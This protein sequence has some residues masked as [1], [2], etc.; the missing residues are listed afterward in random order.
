MSRRGFGLW[1][2]RRRRRIVASSVSTISTLLRFLCLCYT[3]HTMTSNHH[4]GLTAAIVVILVVVAAVLIFRPEAN[5]ESGVEL[6]TFIDKGLTPEAQAEFD[7]RIATLKA[8]IEASEEFNGHDHL[9][10]GNLYYQVG[11]LELAKDAYEAILA[12]SPEDVGALENLGVALELMRDYEGAARAW[13]KALSLSGSVTTVIRLV[14]IIE[15]SLPEQYDRVDDVL[16]LAIKSLGQDEQ[17]NGRLAK[18]YFGNGEYAEAQS[19]YEVAETLSG[20]TG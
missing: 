12:Q 8:S 17:L 14:D 9:L 6:R 4:H 5:H 3:F 19:H 15:N 2:K 7:L 13:T 20:G 11:E 16:E 1:G 18:W 10:L